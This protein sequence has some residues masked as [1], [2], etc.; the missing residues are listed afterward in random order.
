MSPQSNLPA[1][2]RQVV[3]LLDVLLRIRQDVQEKRTGPYVYIGMAD[4]AR[5]STF[6]IGYTQCM[7]SLGV[8]EGSDVLFHDW[9]EILTNPQRGRAW[10]G[11]FLDECGG[12]HE[13]A[14]RKYLD[15]VA[16]FR[17]LSPEA[18]AA[19]P[20]HGQGAH[21][22]NQRPSL[23]STNPPVPTLDM[24]LEARQAIGDVEGRLAMII[25]DI[26]VQRM[27]G[28]IDGYRLCLELSGTRDEEY[29]R[30]EQWLHREKELPPWQT[31]EQS[32]LQASH[33]D[34]EK[35]IRGFLENA[36]EFVRRSRT[37]FPA[38]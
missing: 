34:H 10:D 7:C 35:A 5:L 1:T 26:K 24:L 3:A 15:R 18:L 29:A 27:A 19:I 33:G 37:P 36:A 17:S 31:R 13:C 9:L 22:W 4:A 2:P 25:G 12:D 16:E 14:V 6:S 11:R 38:V 32:L 30:F 8:H 20:Y 21:P 28:L 23:L